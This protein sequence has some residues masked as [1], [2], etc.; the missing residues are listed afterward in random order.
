MT[1]EIIKYDSSFTEATFL[2][3]AEHIYMMMLDAVMEKDLNE[4][5]HYLSEKVYEYLNSM[6]SD[7]TSR[8]VIRIFDETNVKTSSI[9]SYY[10]D[11]ETINIVVNL[12]SRYMDYFID[13]DGNYL[14]GTND[15]RVEREHRIVFTKKFNV[16]HLNEARPCPSCGHSLDV[17]ASGVCPYCKQ[18]IDMS[19]YDYIVSEIDSI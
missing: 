3:K 9:D 12:T 2:T 10:T 18:V 13:D 4:V 16:K 1:E 14:Y 8:N 5:K 15:H 7:Y 17:N 11:E 6:V 19:N